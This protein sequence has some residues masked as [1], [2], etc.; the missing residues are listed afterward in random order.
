MD[1]L[2]V[3]VDDDGVVGAAGIELYGSQGLLRSVVVH[4]DWRGLGIGERLVEEA[5]G[6]ARKSGVRELYLL[7]E[8]AADY[9]ERYQFRSVARDE[10]AGPV[11]ASAEFSY[12]CPSTAEV[13]V[14]ELAD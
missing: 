11:R 9:F 14:R 12:L 8:D 2:L 10:V 13:M 6:V 4:V 5:I 1:T 7:T 3:A